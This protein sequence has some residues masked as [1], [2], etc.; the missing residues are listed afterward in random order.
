MAQSRLTIHRSIT[1]DQPLPGPAE[2]TLQPADRRP[3]ES[4]TSNA[5]D[6]LLTTDGS[7]IDAP[8]ER[9]ANIRGRTGCSVAK[10]LGLRCRPTHNS[11]NCGQ[12]F[13]LRRCSAGPSR[14][15]VKSKGRTP[16]RGP[17]SRCCRWLSEAL[18]G[19]SVSENMSA[20]TSFV[21]KS[22]VVRILGAAGSTFSAAL[23]R[24]TGLIAAHPANGGVVRGGSRGAVTVLRRVWSGARFTTASRPT[25]RG[26]RVGW[27]VVLVGRALVGRHDGSGTRGGPQHAAAPPEPAVAD[28]TRESEPGRVRRPGALRAPIRRR[29]FG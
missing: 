9:L 8:A 16:P 17:V 7:R 29:D 12:R 27:D 11:G 18:E 5:P 4:D 22:T 1:S 2:P 14:S 6:S 3:E 10:A 25:C 15:S 21:A 13:L 26:R 19:G 28:F 20:P 23:A 24:V